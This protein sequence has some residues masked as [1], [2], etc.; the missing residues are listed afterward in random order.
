M[1]GR[2][3]LLTKLTLLSA[4]SY[5]GDL[6]SPLEAA[7]LTHS[8]ADGRNIA[9]PF[10]AAR[11]AESFANLDR[12][13]PLLAWPLMLC[14]FLQHLPPGAVVELDLTEDARQAGEDLSIEVAHE[15]ANEYWSSSAEWSAS[16]ARTL[17]RL[18]A[19][20][21]GAS[22]GA[23][24]EFWFA[25]AADLLGRLK[26]M[27]DTPEVTTKAR[28]DALENLVEAL[29]RTEAPELQILEKNLR[30]RQEE[31]DVVLTNGLKDPFW[32]NLSSPLIL[33]ECKNYGNPVGVPPLRVLESKMADR[34]AL[35]RVGIFVS[36]AGFTKTFLSRLKSLQTADRIVFALDG[37]DLAELVTSKQR[38]T[39][40]LRE[41]GL[42]RSL[43]GRTS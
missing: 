2:T 24:P 5:S 10:A 17:E 31:I 11:A 38:L 26:S 35:C 4:L 39:D 32:T 36:M 7:S 30:T 12:I 41:R 20:L 1:S 29:I 6:P 18:F 28:G 3:T 21:A 43:T 34:G 13:A 15:Y 14:V 33:V 16:Y 23:G 22:A 40:W 37:N 27:R 8:A 42:L 19:V 9:N 25:R